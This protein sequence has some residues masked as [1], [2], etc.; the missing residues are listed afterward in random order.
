MTDMSGRGDQFMR[1]SGVS[2]RYDKLKVEMKRQE[3]D[4]VVAISPENVLYFAETYIQ[5]Q[6]SIRDRLAI[7]VLPLEQDPAIIA[8]VIESPT[9]EHECWIRD[10]RYY[11][12]F[13]ESPIQFLANVLEE[14]GLTHKRIGVELD[15]LS[16]HY[17]QELLERIPNIQLVSCLNAF[18]VVRS[19][20]EE[21][22]IQ[23][24]Q[25]ASL[26]TRD[27]YTKAITEIHPG[28]LETDFSKKIAKYMI[29]G[30]CTNLEFLVM[31]TGERS[32]LV[33]GL[34][35]D[36]P[37][38]NNTHG[39]IDFGGLFNHY[40][41]DVARTFMIGKPNPKHVD[42]VNRMMEVY[43]AA[44]EACKIGTPANSVY[45]TA[46]AMS[47]KVGL[48]FNRVHSGH[49]LGLSIHEYPMLAPENRTLLEENMVMCVEH[50]THVDGY[51]YHIEDLIQ[52][53][54]NGPVVL[55]APE[56]FAPTYQLIL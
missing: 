34:P 31:G 12:E 6:K 7:A 32:I 13:K 42:V 33:H 27:A 55:S 56:G 39:R 17:Y 36:V 15:Y 25:R 9:V 1:D 38:K 48:P 20:K 47:E 45:F 28:D 53:T 46:K 50:A 49:G 10:R 21:K 35:E 51:R 5:T 16:A 19:I 44:V 26:V 24:L 54:P 43:T 4:V 41:S 14:R 2:P 23:I 40:N 3:L 11:F 30:G 8:C 22:E 37:M 52:I 18:N 29:D